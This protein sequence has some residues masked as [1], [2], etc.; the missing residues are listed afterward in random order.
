M[1]DDEVFCHRE[2]KRFPRA[3]FDEISGRGLVHVRGLAAGVP[4]HTTMDD[5]VDP[6]TGGGG[7]TVGSSEVLREPVFKMPPGF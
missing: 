5:R 2:E 1:G 4:W 6:P 3:D 7:G